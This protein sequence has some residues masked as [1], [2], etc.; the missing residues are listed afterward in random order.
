MLRRKLFL[1][2]SCL[3]L[4]LG[5]ALCDAARPR[6]PKKSAAPA[7]AAEVK[8][9]KV[10]EARLIACSNKAQS[11]YDK[12]QFLQ[13]EEQF[14]QCLLIAPRD[15]NT[16]LSLAGVLMEQNKLEEAKKQFDAAV[17][18]LPSSSTLTAYA[19][20]RLGDI[21]LK[22]YR[23]KDAGPYYKKALELDQSDIN[24]QV[25]LGKYYEATENWKDAAAAYRAG[26]ALDPINP[27]AGKG[28]RRVEPYVMT[29]AEILEELK[30]RRVIPPVKNELDK[31]GRVWFQLIR[32]AE[33]Y[34][35][36]EYL[37]GKLKKIPPHY[38]IKKTYPDGQFRMLL[39]WQG[40]S[41]FRSAINKDVIEYFNSQKVASKF[42][43]KIKSHS[44]KPL[45]S[46]QGELTAEGMEVYFLALAGR[47]YYTL[48]WEDSPDAL[49]AS[50]KQG[51]APAPEPDS[52]EIVQA[53][54]DGHVEITGNEY[55]WLKKT[56]DCSEK[57]FM[58]SF[59]LRVI[60]TAKGSTRY[61][62]HTVDYPKNIPYSYIVDYRAGKR[63]AG[64]GSKG[65]FG[66]AE[67]PE[68]KLCSSRGDLVDDDT[69]ND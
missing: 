42:I 68:A 16:L 38:Y 34:N 52:P 65:L 12:K 24:A 3:A 26:L 54:K 58:E 23:P 33:N 53:R 2:S 63:G 19:Y 7:V 57:T 18:F 22:L 45:F 60:H 9:S 46:P 47:K 29:D 40:Y 8:L 59:D 67:T 15:P 20:S 27:I 35:A 13:S 49:L 64:S 14:R 50:S 5:P 62:L 55:E 10:E 32:A 41:V 39:T 36:L 48:P 21:C 61:F 31:D 11:L 37:R 30:L 66:S 43:F 69:D 25:G 51:Q 6:A 44:G 17:T 56:T 1:L 28:L 4:V